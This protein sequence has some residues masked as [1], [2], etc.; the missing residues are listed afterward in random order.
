LDLTGAGYVFVAVP[1]AFGIGFA[2]AGATC[3]ENHRDA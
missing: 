3:P 2:M 1:K